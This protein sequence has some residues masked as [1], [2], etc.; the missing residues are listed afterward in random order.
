MGWAAWAVLLIGV[1]ADGATNEPARGLSGR[2]HS[3][4]SRSIPRASGRVFSLVMEN[5]FIA[6]ADHDYSH[7]LSLAWGTGNVASRP[8]DSRLR[9]WTET[10][11]FLPWVSAEDSEKY[12]TFRLVQQIFT[13]E[14]IEAELPPA[15]QH[16]YAGLL[17]GQATLHARRPRSQHDYALIAGMV[18]PSVVAG[19]L[20]RLSHKTIG[21][22]E[23]NG[24]D[25]QLEDEPLINLNYSY[26]RRLI[27][28]S[29]ERSLQW[30]LASLIGA[31]AG[32]YMVGA[33]AGLNLRVGFH[34]PETYEGFGMRLGFATDSVPTGP[35]CNE[36]WGLFASFAARGVALAH[37]MPHGNVWASGYS[38]DTEP[39]I[40]VQEVGLH[41]YYRRMT[42]S[43]KWVT[44]SDYYATQSGEVAY[45]SLAL[46][47]E[48]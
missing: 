15:G 9:S 26:E 28:S 12:W 44:G 42:L 24:W 18:G 25:E 41:L 37:Y 27:A 17:F 30:D 45:G 47:F 6:H 35:P 23:A 33:A 39:W 14:D 48:Y 21:S 40:T 43:H 31:G 5:D 8:D 16:P 34:L 32:T 2:D 22:S 4:V 46:S 38:V 10:L 3:D 1:F 7:A 11:R 19:E 36:R 29:C 13:P 20:Y